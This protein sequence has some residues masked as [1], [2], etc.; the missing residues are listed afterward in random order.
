[1]DLNNL[2]INSEQEDLESQKNNYGPNLPEEHSSSSDYLIVDTSDGKSFLEKVKRIKEPFPE[3]VVYGVY[4]NAGKGWLTRLNDFFVDRGKVSLKDKSYFFHMLAV[5][6]DSGIPLVKAISSLSDRTENHKFRRVLSTI[7][8][9]CERGSNFADSMARFEDVFDEAEI[10]VVRAGEATGRLHLMLADLSN[11]LE[12][13]YDLS[14][15][16]WGASVYPIA[17]LSV[18]IVVSLGILIWVLPIL[19]NLFDQGGIA[20]ESLPSSTRFL[21]VIQNVIVGYWGV[22]LVALLV[23]YGLFVMYKNSLYGATRWD[24]RKLTLPVV[25]GLLKKLYVQRFVGILGILVSSGVPVM[26]ALSIAGNSLPN[27]IYKLKVQEVIG[28]VRAGRKISQSLEDSEFLF[29]PEV[30]QM[31]SVGE[32]S[33]SLGEITKKIEIQYGMEISNSLKKMTSVFEPVMILVV[34]LLVGLLALSIMA[35]IFNLGSV[36]G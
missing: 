10:G 28:E 33:A 8:Y 7:A 13:R 36:I 34:G 6:V 2:K 5:M 17:V 30:V 4:N 35:P 21:I 1:M 14:L 22:I 9:D 11:Q 27:R 18:L 19:L 31:I 25:G 29:P 20:R 23:S 15:K 16:L 24:Y 12:K 26:K 32:K 3:K